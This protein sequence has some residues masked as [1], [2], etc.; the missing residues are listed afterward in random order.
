[1][2]FKNLYILSITIAFMAFSQDKCQAETKGEKVDI[3]IDVTKTVGQINR[4][5]AGIMTDPPK[6]DAYMNALIKR[7]KIEGNEQWMKKHINGANAFWLPELNPTFINLGWGGDTWYFFNTW[8]AEGE[9]NWEKLDAWIESHIERGASNL[10]LVL[11]YVPE[12]LWTP[13]DDAAEESGAAI[14]WFPYLK[15]G[16]VRPPADYEKYEEIIYQTVRHLNVEKKKEPFFLY[17]AHPLVHSPIEA[18]EA[19]V[20]KYK[21]K[22]ATTLPAHPTYAAMVENLDTSI[23]KIIDGLRERDQLDN[24]LIIF[25]SD[26]GAMTGPTTRTKELDGFGL[27]IFT[28]HYPLRGGKVQLWEG[29]I[30]IPFG[31]AFGDR[32][33]RGTFDGMVSQMD[34][35]PTILDIAGHPD[36]GN[37]QAEFGGKT[38]RPILENPRSKWEERSLFWHYPGYRGLAYKPKFEGQEAGFDQRPVSVIRRG[39]WKLFESLETGK[40]QLYNLKKDISE[41]NN[42]ADENSELAASLLQELKA[43]QKETNAP[44]PI[45]K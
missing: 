7:L 22:S 6:T 16:N 13:A 34:I 9:Y 17:L 40:V 4:D 28:S 44:M 11:A 21:N 23:G 8:P 45:P 18:E 15:K 19:L 2:S 14:N 37:I 26:N 33:S 24:T 32:I 10:S 30:R 36:F 31:M 3:Q 27:G 12:W 1:M 5:I 29:G 25:T 38:L 35:L 42:I 41:K 39:D 43:W 20:N